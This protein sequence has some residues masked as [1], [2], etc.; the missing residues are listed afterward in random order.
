MKVR[1]IADRAA[2]YGIPG[3]TV[4]GNDVMAVYEVVSE[5][6]ARARKGDGPS[7]IECITWRHHGHFEGDSCNYRLKEDETAWMKRDPIPHFKEHLIGKG[8]FTE[9]DLNEIQKNIKDEIDQAVK[10]AEESPLP[11]VEETLEDVYA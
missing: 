8:V 6:V 4:D 11:S 10:F 1:D 7:L 2:A 9:K 3:I 5:A